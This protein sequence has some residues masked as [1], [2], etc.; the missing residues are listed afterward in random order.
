MDDMLLRAAGGGRAI[1]SGSPPHDPLAEIVEHVSDLRRVIVALMTERLE[2]ELGDR[3]QSVRRII[4]RGSPMD[5]LVTFRDVDGP[6]SGGV[7]VS[8]SG[9]EKCIVPREIQ[10]LITSRIRNVRSVVE[11]A[12]ARRAEEIRS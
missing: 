5:F 9:L 11:A 2:R 3:I 4:R 6:A 12:L 10:D 1:D 8:L 7:V